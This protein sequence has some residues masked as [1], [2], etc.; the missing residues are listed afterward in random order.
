MYIGSFP[1]STGYFF[2]HVQ[3]DGPALTVLSEEVVDL[4]ELARKQRWHECIRGDVENRKVL[5]DGSHILGTVWWV[6][7]TEKH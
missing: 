5:V 1:L 2:S 7:T 3:R 4:L 6:L